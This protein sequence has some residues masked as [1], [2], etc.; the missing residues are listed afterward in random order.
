MKAQAEAGQQIK[1]VF[2]RDGAVSLGGKTS[3]HQVSQ[4]L[5]HSGLVREFTGSRKIPDKCS[6]FSV[7]CV[8]GLFL[9]RISLEIISLERRSESL[10]HAHAVEEQTASLSEV[11]ELSREFLSRFPC[12]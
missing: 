12:L 9:E 1:R 4:K 8:Q 7:L 2:Q 10:L 5:L 6:V 11:T 3:T